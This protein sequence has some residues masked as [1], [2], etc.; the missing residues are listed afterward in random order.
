MAGIES[1]LQE[2]EACVKL[3]RSTYDHTNLLT[4]V[5]INVYHDSQAKGRTLLQTSARQL[6]AARLVAATSSHGQE[7][8][9]LSRVVLA[10]RRTALKQNFDSAVRHSRQYARRHHLLPTKD[11]QQQQQQQQQ[12]GDNGANATAQ[13]KQMVQSLNRSKIVV[14]E[15]L[16]S[17]AAANSVLDEDAESLEKTGRIHGEYGSTMSKASSRLAE[18]KRLEELANTRMKWSFGLFVCV[19]LFVMIR[20]LPFLGMFMW[21]MRTVVPRVLSL[22]G[23]SGTDGENQMESSS[24]GLAACIP[25]Q[26]QV[27]TSHFAMKQWPSSVP[28]SII[29]QVGDFAV[30]SS[31]CVS[32]TN[33]DAASCTMGIGKG[34]CFTTTGTP[35]LLN[36][37]SLCGSGNLPQCSVVFASCCGGSVVSLNSK[38]YVFTLD[39]DVAAKQEEEQ[40]EQTKEDERKLQEEESKQEERLKAKQEVERKE[41]EEEGKEEERLTV[42]A[43]AVAAVKQKEKEKKEERDRVAAVAVKQKEEDEEKE[44]A[45]VAAV[46]VK[47]KEEEKEKKEERDRVAA[48]VVKQKEEDEEKERARVAADAAAAQAHQEESEKEQEKKIVAAIAAAEVAAAEAKAAEVEARQQ[49]ERAKEKEIDDL[50]ENEK[51]QEQENKRAAAAAISAVAATPP[52]PTPLT[53]P[54]PIAQK[55]GAQVTNPGNVPTAVISEI[56]P[57]NKPVVE[58]NS[59]VMMPEQGIISDTQNEL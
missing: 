56:K 29:E 54:T 6:E 51:E 52:P 30:F 23:G 9:E 42:V 18:M 19:W 34:T 44:R 59:H 50:E 22:F 35:F 25:P 5:D 21:I 49:E 8:N 20:R 40:E 45:R 15:I 43:A 7:A 24:G 1:T 10:R 33:D 31:V 36:L 53:L 55:A 57:T 38:P 4:T 2:L 32:L 41:K 27:A 17:T 58:S 26:L 12:D 37:E 39:V 28:V 48:V 14:Q 3:L 46:A 47:Q 11:T 13:A 16:E